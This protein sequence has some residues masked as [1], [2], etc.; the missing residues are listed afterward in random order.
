MEK[1]FW[2]QSYSA[3]P[4]L[5]CP[6]CAKGSVRVKKDTVQRLEPHHSK[7]NHGNDDWFVHDIVERFTCLMI[8]SASFC[9]EVVAVTGSVGYEEEPYHDQDGELD[10]TTNTY[11][12]PRTFFP[13]PPVISVSARLS[14]QCRLDLTSSFGL[15]WC[16]GE[17]ETSLTREISRRSR[18]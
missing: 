6:R 9:G 3:I 18:S 12:Y 7:I 16:D 14:E 11:F 5:R 1:S 13:A 10:Y 4:A 8:C 2:R 17:Q 15:L